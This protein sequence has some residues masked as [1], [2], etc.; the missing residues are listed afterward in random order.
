MKITQRYVDSLA[1]ANGKAKEAPAKDV[2]HRDDGLTGFGVKL[3]AKSGTISFIFEGWI[4]NRG[5]K[6]IT[7]GRYPSQ[8]VKEAKD[9]ALEA[10]RQFKNGIDPREQEKQTQEDNAT[11]KAL[12]A[13]LSVTLQEVI[14]DYFIYKKIKSEEEYRAV[15]SREFS[16]WLDK[17]VKDL[18]EEGVIQWFNKK[19]HIDG[20]KAQA[21]KGLKYLR[22][23]LNHATK[24]KKHGEYLLTEN[25]VEMTLNKLPRDDKKP[26]APKESYI[27]SD[28]LFPFF[29]GVITECKSTARDLL[30]LQLFTGLRDSEAKGLLWKDVDLEKKIFTVRDTKGK[31][32]HSPPMSAFLYA[33]LLHRKLNQENE[34]Y[35]FSN[36]ANTGKLGDIR[37][38]INKVTAKTGIEFSHHDLRRTFATILEQELGVPDGVISRLLN[39]APSSVTDKHYIKSKTSNYVDLSNKFYLWILGEN[40][41]TRDDGKD[42]ITDELFSKMDLDEIAYNNS[43]IDILYG[44]VLEEAISR[45]DLE[46]LAEG[47][48]LAS[49][50]LKEERDFQ[51]AIEAGA[52]DKL[53]G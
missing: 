24:T 27:E 14:E 47:A 39:H 45:G 11:K 23:M 9:K 12:D 17:P 18:T 30:L 46:Y 19:A 3:A 48:G 21:Q 35:V 33:L 34:T 43:L 49:L 1:D 4:R 41:F 2:Y 25:V 10:Q 53:Q 40:D 22:A 44:D 52:Y 31:S 8:Q 28:Q 38:Q 37:K 5:S 16:E 6:R 36:R 7:L 29:R 42:Q 26:S 15:I 13:A 20:H 32:D 50:K 51:E